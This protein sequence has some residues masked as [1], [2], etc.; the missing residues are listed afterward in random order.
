MAVSGACHQWTVTVA[1]AAVGD[2]RTLT[3]TVSKYLP[4]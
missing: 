2:N 3:Q 4:T 1:G